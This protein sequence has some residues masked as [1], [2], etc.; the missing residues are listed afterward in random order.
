M[1]AASQVS[2][3][4]HLDNRRVQLSSNQCR[5]VLCL[6]EELAISELALYS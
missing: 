3:T 1:R 6:V 4:R 5:L 2:T